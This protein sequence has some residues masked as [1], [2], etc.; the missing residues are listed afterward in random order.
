MGAVNGSFKAEF[1]KF[2]RNLVTEF[3]E[4]QSIIVREYLR[5][6][7]FITHN[8]DYEWRD[9]SFGLQPDVNHKQAAGAITLT[10]C[11]IYHPSQSKLTGSEIAFCGATAYGLKH[12]NYL[13]LET[14]AQGLI[15]WL[16]YP[17][18]LRL[19]AYSH[20]AAG[21]CGVM[22]WHW[23]SIHHSQETYWKGVLS[24]D[25]EPNAIYREACNI[26]KEIAAL[27]PHLQ[28]LQKK[29]KTAILVSNESLSGI[30]IFHFP[31]RSFEY[32]DIL[33]WMHD[34][35]Y[36]MNIEADIIFPEDAEQFAQYDMLLVPALYSAPNSL[37]EA[38]EAYAKNGGYLIYGYR[39][40]FSNEFLEVRSK[41]QPTPHFFGVEYDLF[42]KP[43][44]VALKSELFP[45]GDYYATHWMEMLCP[46]TAEAIATYDHPAWG[47]YAAVTKCKIGKGTGIYIGCHMDKSALKILLKGF[48]E[49]AGLW[50]KVQQ[51]QFP[52]IIKSGLSKEGH[53]VHFYL[54]Y[55]DD[56][57]KQ[58]YYHKNATELITGKHYA[59]GDMLE[60]APWGVCVLEE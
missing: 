43:K 34:A 47:Q 3:L 60:L 52:V 20:L 39:S 41:K 16:P 26:G 55:S 36:E 8:F 4:W 1:E 17:G 27:S 14:E 42:T 29:N 50:T 31:D 19:Q 15:E 48:L 38:L 51:T 7:Q 33:R 32:N 56:S 37:L 58:E 13:V 45:N 35:L 44:D 25:M 28:G 2:R 10:G 6:D 53:K 59:E 57:L 21:A 30:K 9:H 24:H 11:D 18:Q 40:G 49:E 22:Y 46:T 5:D 12:D 54:N 23:H